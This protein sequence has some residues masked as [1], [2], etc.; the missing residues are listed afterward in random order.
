M[1]LVD[2][3]DENDKIIR[4]VDW[5]DAT[6]SDIQRCAVV[7]I[8]NEKGE[9]LLQLRSEKEKHYPL[10]WDISAGGHLAHCSK[11]YS[12]ENLRLIRKRLKR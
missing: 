2:V 10:C 5:K 4:S 9:I 1:S 7:F 8:F 3:V 11:A 6:N 12:T